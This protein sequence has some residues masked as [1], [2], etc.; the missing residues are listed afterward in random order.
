[1][2]AVVELSERTLYLN[3]FMRTVYDHTRHHVGDYKWSARS[4]DSRGWV[5]CD[6]RSLSRTEYPELFETIGTTFGAIDS[7]TFKLPDARGRI[8][9]AA[10]ATP[11][12]ALGSVRGAESTTL[13]LNNLPAHTHSGTTDASGSHTHTTNAT[14]GSLGLAV[15]DGSN[16]VVDTDSSGGELNVWTLPRAL[17]VDS[18][19]SHTH[20]F[21]TGSTGDGQPFSIIQ[22]TLYGGNLFIYAG[23]A[24]S[25]AT[26]N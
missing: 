23:F 16:T 20:T 5:L 10:G 4:E 12:Q 14:G 1:M 18:D 17:T 2:T 7:N 8:M 3:Q 26:D 21:T 6:G 22:P 15:A 24:V 19:G 13:T 11:Q 25:L 9:A